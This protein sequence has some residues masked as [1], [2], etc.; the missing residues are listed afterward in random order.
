MKKYLALV[1]AVCLVLG[2]AA[3]ASGAGSATST[4]FVLQNLGSA[5]ASA[6]VEFRNPDGTI[7][8]SYPGITI[9]VGTAK[10]FD[11]RYDANLGTSF[12]GSV[13]ASSDQQLGSVVNLMRIANTM[14]AVNSYESY[15]GF[16]ATS[17]GAD[18]RLPQVLKT[19]S[20]AGLIWNTDI[21]IQ[22]T[23]TG[24]SAS[25]ELVF[26]PDPVLNPAICTA[27]SVCITQPYTK[28]GITV[29][30]GG[31]YNLAQ[32]GQPNTE[33]G[34]KFFGSVRVLS[35]KNVAVQ[36][37]AT[38]TLGGLDQVL[39]A[40]PSYSAGTT[41]PIVMPSVYKAI[42]SLGDSY[43]TSFLI[44]NMGDTAATV[45][46]TY[47]VGTV[48]TVV[49]FDEVTVPAKGVKNVDQR[50]DA[51]SITSATFLGS[52]KI[53][54]M[55]GVPVAAFANLRGG[56]RYAFSYDGLTSGATKVYLPVGY[57]NISSAGYSWASTVVVSNFGAPGTTAHV[58]ISYYDNRVGI[59]PVTNM[60][61]VRCVDDPAVR[62]S[63]PYLDRRLLDIL[64]RDRARVGSA[65]R[66]N[67]P[68][69]RFGRLR[70]RG[71]C[72]QGPRPVRSG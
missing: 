17:I 44:A 4:S 26:T 38:G 21:T 46:I 42:M 18:I 39:V 32:A 45:R 52:A 60:G 48:G 70:R 61:P 50:Y 24:A 15:N 71:A 43:S 34:D 69:P 36:T 62:P 5:E 30:A 67:G 27:P 63:V 9:A 56:S 35:S 57:K 22:N 49:G 65:D 6:T 54:P 41:N 10:S 58:R 53:T 29:L 59:A 7:K 12:S 1:L 11:Q 8:Y 23:D 20:S 33:I 72:L 19:V 2:V 47:T 3:I 55:N 37:L 66:R 68:D 51:P 31:S 16:D 40:Y 13:I 25:V 14:G 28:T 64:R